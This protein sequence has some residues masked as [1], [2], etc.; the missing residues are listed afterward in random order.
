[1]SISTKEDSQNPAA[2]IEGPTDNLQD[3]NVNWGLLKKISFRYMFVYLILYSFPFPLKYIPYLQYFSE[4]YEQ[5]W[6]TL[7]PW[8][9]KHILHVSYE[10]NVLF[11]GSGDTTYHYIQLLCFLILSMAITLV[12]SAI[13]RKRPNYQYLHQWLKVYMRLSLASALITY[14]AIKLYK[15]QFPDPSLDRLIEPYG[16]SSPMGLLWTFMGNSRGYNIFTGAAEMLGG[17]LLF[18]PRTVTLGALVSIGVMG[19]VVMLNFCYDVPVKIYSTHLLLISFFLV[20]ADLIRLSKIFILNL[21]V[22][23]VKHRPLF[24]N[25]RLNYAAVILRLIL[26]ILILNASLQLTYSGLQWG[27]LAP[28]SP[29]YGIWKVAEFNKDNVIQPL[30]ITDEQLWRRI[31]FMEL[32]TMCVQS[33]SDKLQYYYQQTDMWRQLILMRKANDQ[34]W[35]TVFS[36]TQPSINQLNLEGDMDGHHIKIKLVRI[37]EDQF[38][39]TN[40]G[41]HWINE[42]PFNQ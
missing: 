4:K 34:N 41:F 36:F 27:E 7:V 39:L 30:L 38:L 2:T 40:R 35:Q 3:S 22:E 8:I 25:S 18:L 20:S 37:D 15:S 23:V 42:Y 12:W 24:K 29:L 32:P 26:L 16:N 5:C 19:N 31:V 11:N 1:M 28:K 13:D 10:I 21:P 9:G 17:L 6:K 33:M 14:G